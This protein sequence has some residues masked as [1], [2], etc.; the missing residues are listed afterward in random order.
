MF[1]IFMSWWHALNR[2]TDMSTLWPICRDESEDMN[3][4][5]MAFYLHVSNDPAWTNYY[6]EDDL[7]DFVGQLP[8][9]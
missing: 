8:R 6:T 2:R 1:K 9:E 7:I 5:R 4:A 3:Q